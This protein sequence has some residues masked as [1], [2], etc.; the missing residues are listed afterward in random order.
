MR[1]S[2]VIGIPY[3]D[4]AVRDVDMRMRTYVTRKYYGAVQRAG[5]RVLL[6]PPSAEGD[7]LDY[8]LDL[9]DGLVLA[10]G[11]DV[12]PIHQNE[13]PHPKL[14]GV[15][16][17]RDA[18]ELELTRRAYRRRLPTFGICR[19]VQVLAIALGGSIHQDLEGVARIKHEQ[20]APRWA[21]S[22]R[23]SLVEG[24]VLHRWL[25]TT[26]MAVNSFHH[27]AV[28]D[29]P[30]GFRVAGT[31]S[32]GVVEV[33]EATDDRICLGV[34]WHPEEMALTDPVAAKIFTEFVASCRQ[35]PVVSG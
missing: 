18:F 20:Q 33:M 6:L 11:E 4:M 31:T 15:N 25:G 17:L 9:L 16:P 30:A 13:D 32:D 8:Y 29:L 28:R 10:G 24:S 7:D 3:A 14:S 5:A 34:Q 19:G 12:D 35:K 26:T 1:Q 2:P 21:A 22:H 23:V 27:Q